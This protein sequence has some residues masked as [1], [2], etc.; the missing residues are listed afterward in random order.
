MKTYDDLFGGLS[1]IVEHYREQPLPKLEDFL[2]SLL[3]RASCFANRDFFE[4]EEFF[5]LVRDSF[6]GPGD[7]RE[8]VS[9]EDYV[10]GFAVWKAEMEAQIRDLRD[11][12]E[13]G[14]LEN[15]YRYSGITSPRGRSWYNFD[16][17]S[18]IDCAM[19]GAWCNG[20][21]GDDEY[22]PTKS[23]PDEPHGPKPSHPAI[24][25]HDFDSFIWCGR[26]YE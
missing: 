22:I 19:S 20:D 21:Y 23:D 5:H 13:N 18:Y 2:A 25:W 10:S 24:T 7:D 9:E 1:E 11:M 17:A 26:I 15:K 14:Q 12:A 6:E 3:R 8:V 4:L 16:P